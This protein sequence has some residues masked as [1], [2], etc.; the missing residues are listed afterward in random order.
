MQAL[1]QHQRDVVMNDFVSEYAALIGNK[2]SDVRLFGSSARG[3]VREYIAKRISM[4]S[5]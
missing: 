2:L 3:V 1:A 4:E 5:C